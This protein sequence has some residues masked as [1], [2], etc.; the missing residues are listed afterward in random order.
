[1]TIISEVLPRGCDHSI[2]NKL[3]ITIVV[4]SQTCDYR[5]LYGV[6]YSDAANESVM[7]S[8]QCNVIGQYSTGVC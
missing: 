6:V 4:M 8:F 2:I 7:F 5:V 1:M 3:E